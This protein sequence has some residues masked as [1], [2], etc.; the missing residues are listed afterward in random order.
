[1][2]AKRTLIAILLAVAAILAVVGTQCS[3]PDPQPDE[4]KAVERP[5]SDKPDPEPGEDDQVEEYEHELVEQEPPE[6]PLQLTFVDAG[7]AHA[8][9]LQKGSLDILVDAGRHYNEELRQ[10]M[11]G[12]TG[13]LDLLIITHPHDDHFG[14][15]IDLLG[16]HEV[17][18]VITNGERRE[19]PRDDEPLARWSQFEEAVDE[20]GL[21]LEA[22]EARNETGLPE[23]LQMAGHFLLLFR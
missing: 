8:L 15:A 16:D 6:Q 17:E 14:G 7:Q 18:Q 21:E 12:I 2:N 20:A 4:D 1:M 9:H 23:P 19:P 3:T 13:S 22:W 10:A 11:D 5:T